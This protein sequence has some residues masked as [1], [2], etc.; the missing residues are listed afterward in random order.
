MNIGTGSIRNTLVALSCMGIIAGAVAVLL[1]KP[2][3]SA[4]CEDTRVIRML[5][6]PDSI[7]TGTEPLVNP[8][9]YKIY[10]RYF[11]LPK[12]RSFA[13]EDDISIF[14][15]GLSVLDE[16]DLCQQSNSMQSIRLIF[17][18]SNMQIIRIDKQDGFIELYSSE[19]HSMIGG[20]TTDIRDCY[21]V[22]LCP[23]VWDSL[24]V[25][26]KE[27]RLDTVQRYRTPDYWEIDGYSYVLEI[28]TDGSY[29]SF[30]RDYIY[31]PFDKI[32]PFIHNLDKY[33][34]RRG[35]LKSMFYREVGTT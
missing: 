12:V 24:Y 1:V 3:F 32:I 26:L 25:R 6:Q 17:Y 15:T 16:P 4:S 30:F 19:L 5:Y 2:S 29:R 9:K 13:R 18:T 20:G 14:A 8:A 27:S 7:Y 31:P 10:S 33:Q 21:C 22:R 34:R 35:G 23:S 28:K 11:G